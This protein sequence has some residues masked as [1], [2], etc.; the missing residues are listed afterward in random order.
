MRVSTIRTLLAVT[1]M[2]AVGFAGSSA[3]AAT[4]L[5]SWD[6]ETNT[7][8]DL[9]NSATGPSVASEGGIHAGTL[10]GVHASAD[11]DWSTPAGNGSA[12]SYS[13]NTWAVDDYTQVST[14]TLGYD[15]LGITFDVTSSN[16]GPKDFKIQTSTDGS[17]FTDTGITYVALA[18]A[19]PNPVWNATTASAIYTVSASLPSSINDLA[20]AYIRLVDTSTVSANGGAV[21]AGGTHRIDN[22][23][24]SG[25]AIVPEPAT[26]A[27]VSLAGLAIV[28]VA[29]R[30][31]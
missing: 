8:A 11:S 29:R 10:Q 22:V 17:A 3:I 7:P 27:L 13:V 4:I 14:S 20:A 28:G 25:E 23:S 26:L 5:S 16:T 12:N 15:T 9:N 21:A 19:S 6:F 30:R 24:I 18:N 2:I 31:S 1:S